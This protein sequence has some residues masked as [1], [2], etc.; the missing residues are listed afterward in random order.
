[1]EYYSSLDASQ[2]DSERPTLFEI[3]SSNQLEALLSPSLRYILVHYASKYPRYLLKINNRFDE[4][5]LFF[6]GFIEW[7][8]LKYWQGSF[9]ENFYGLKR[10]NQTPLSQGDYN[11]NKLTSVVPSMVEERRQLTTLQILVSIFE[12]TGV[13]YL[14]E[15]MNYSYEVWYTKYVTNQLNTHESNTREENFK[16]QL[17]R[18]FVQIYPYLQSA[19]RLGN[20][21]TI[22]LYLSGST[23]SPTLLT[24]LFR[25]N[26]SRLNQ[27]DY[28][29]NDSSVAELNPKT[30]L[31]EIA[32]PTGFE[33]LLRFANT[34]IWGPAL[35][36]IK[37]ILGTFFPGAIFTLKF[38][39]WWNN[40]DFSSK[41]AKNQGNVLDFT[42]PPPSTLTAAL[43]ASRK[44]VQEKKKKGRKPY[45]SGKECPLCKKELSNPAIIETGYVFDYSCIY[46]Y[47]EK[48]HII[49]SK[50][51]ES[52]KKE[53]NEKDYSDD[54]EEEQQDEEAE[55]VTKIDIN[56]GGRCPITG[57]KLLGC[58]WNAIREEWDIEGIRRLIF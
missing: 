1:M 2:L 14:S 46:N 35:N 50:K 33:W 10:V 28:S 32:P 18:K 29:K 3:I 13:A 8:F 4:I 41:L 19:Y 36:L 27:Y 6:R 43:S 16:I 37:F 26:Y 34:N 45:V 52:K 12:V 40:S 9:T 11:S 15:K 39:E 42:L 17:K 22:L 23:K 53:L 54:D 25:M 48:S 5:N 56:K 21:V 58:R 49:V 24:Y 31:N 57:K 30:P 55:E 51:A 47:L 38:L 44:V 20:F 7:Y